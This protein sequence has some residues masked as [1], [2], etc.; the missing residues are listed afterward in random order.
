VRERL[1]HALN[2]YLYHA[3]LPDDIDEMRLRK[4]ILVGMVTLTTICGFIWGGM[5]YALG[6]PYSGIIPVGYSII[7]GISL[8]HFL[9]FKQY[10]LFGYSQIF[11]IMLLPVLLQWSLGGFEA[12]SAVIIWSFAASMGA[13]IFFGASHGGRW[14]AIFVAVLLVSGIFDSTL[15]QNSA[16]IP[17]NLRTVFY[18]MN[19]LGPTGVS[20]AILMYFVM[21]RDEAQKM[22]E[23]LLLNILPYPIAQRLKQEPEMIADEFSEVTIM[24][25][26]IVNFTP[27][28]QQITPKSLVSILSEIFS[29]IDTIADK[30]GLEKIKTIGDAY[31]AVAGLPKHRED[32][33]EAVAEMTL[34]MLENLEKLEVWRENDLAFRIGVNTGPVVA[35]VIGKKKFI[36]DLWGDA[37]NTASRM[38]SH[39]KPGEIQVTRATY[40]KLKHKYILESR[41]VITVK[42]KGEME[43][44]LLVGRKPEDTSSEMAS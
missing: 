39:G 29:T 41:G 24:F 6:Y 35:G 26:D 32:H 38:E 21:Q 36:Y 4:A 25:A 17:D 14:F 7:C 23:R 19:I 10:K 44:Y 40:E 2:Q 43:T 33:A 9:V 15:A 37:V 42:G 31:M 5:Y 8:I 22:S 13:L 34:E 18:V 28:S 20:Y 12:G 1:L 11:L 27:L 16:D 3:T 30:H